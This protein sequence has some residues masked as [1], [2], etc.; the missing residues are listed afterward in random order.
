MAEVEIGKVTHYFGKI[1]VAAIEITS[2]SLAVG[3]TIHIKGHTSDFTQTV[4]SMQIEGESVQE[5]GVGQ[6]VGVKVSQHAREHDTVY[7]VVD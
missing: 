2:G 1:G 3:D 4:E 6:A 7:K 5:A